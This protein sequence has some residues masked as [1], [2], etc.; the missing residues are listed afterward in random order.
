MFRILLESVLF[1]AQLLSLLQASLQF[2]SADY[3]VLQKTT[4][5]NNP[6][7]VQYFIPPADRDRLRNSQSIRLSTR[8]I[9]RSVAQCRI[10][11]RLE[12]CYPSPSYSSHNSIVIPG[13]IIR[14][15]MQV[16]EA[17][18]RAECACSH[19]PRTPRATP[20]SGLP[21]PDWHRPVTY[22]FLW[23]TPFCVKDM[24]VWSSVAG[25]C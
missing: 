10:G 25:L 24:S 8:S 22:K 6:V 17:A 18:F 13:P 12:Y 21:I 23:Q 16:T 5:L 15:L 11:V 9:Y 20:P 2:S 3:V 14:T 7:L 19:G 4:L 1:G